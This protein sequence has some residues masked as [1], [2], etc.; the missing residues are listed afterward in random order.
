M[1]EQEYTLD[2]NGYYEE[3]HDL[4][5]IITMLEESLNIE[6]IKVDMLERKL[7]VTVEFITTVRGATDHPMLELGCDNILE[8]LKEKQWIQK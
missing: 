2:H 7:E 8:K 3:L 4:R 1:S 6:R 5:G